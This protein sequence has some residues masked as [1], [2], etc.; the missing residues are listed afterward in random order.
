MDM[1]FPEPTL[2]RSDSVDVVLEARGLAVSY[3]GIYRLSHVDVSFPRNSVTAILGASGCGKST[4]LRALNRTL[5]LIPGAR[6]DAGRVLLEREDIY[7]E[8]VSA[9]W[10][11]SRVGMLQQKPAP[12]PMSILENVLFGARYH[13]A[14]NGPALA[15]ARRYLEK[16]GLWEEVKGR[17]RTSALTL[18]GGQQQRLCL[19]RTLAV[20]PSIVLMDEPCSALDPRATAAIEALLR[21]LARDYTIVIVTHN[22]AQARRVARH[23]VFMQDGTI[24]AAGSREEMLIH[25]SHPTV[26]DFVTGTVG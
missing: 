21:D 26:R 6:I 9:P 1:L 24:L 7:A 23:C 25:P 5:E 14:V 4:L 3:G 22:V 19:A 15:E 8:G 10:I 13:G 20:C 16:V 2:V 12:F 17:L 11:R 18:S